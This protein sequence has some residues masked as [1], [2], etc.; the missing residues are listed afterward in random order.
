MEVVTLLEWSKEERD[1][2]GV[3][4]IRAGAVREFPMTNC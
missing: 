4:S 2:V 3:N 1:E